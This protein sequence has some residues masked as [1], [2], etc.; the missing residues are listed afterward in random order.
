MWSLSPFLA[1]LKINIIRLIPLDPVT[2]G[3]EASTSTI[4]T[5]SAEDLNDVYLSSMKFITSEFCCT[6]IFHKENT[7]PQRENTRPQRQNTVLPSSGI[8]KYLG[9]RLVRY[10][11]FNT[12]K[13]S[14]VQ[15][16]SAFFHISFSIN[17]HSNRNWVLSPIWSF[18]NS[19]F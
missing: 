15:N 19:I 14:K 8:F 11:F 4:H 13:T 9:R 6:V 16:L 18:F 10:I 1:N 17:I 7:R 2:F 3:D 12:L 5:P